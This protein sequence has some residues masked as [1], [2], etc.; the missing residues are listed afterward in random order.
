MSLQ[1][2]NV[3]I[4]GATSGFGAQIASV[5]SGER[6][7]VFIGGRRVDRGTQVAQDTNSTFHVVDVADEESCQTFFAAAEACFGGPNA[8]FIILNAGLGGTAAETVVPNL[9][10]QSF[11]LCFGVNVRGIFLGLQYGTPL[12]RTGGTFIFTSSVVSILPAAFNPVYG[13]SKAAVDSLVRSYAA[14]F[15][16]SPDARI[17]SLSVIAINPALYATE[18][19]CRYLKN[20]EHIFAATAKIY[21]PSQ[22]VG[23]AE[24]LA[25]IVRDLVTGKRPYKSGDT[26]ACDADTHFPLDE[27]VSRLKAGQETAKVES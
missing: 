2:K 20:D 4:T 3:I 8:D 5:L 9:N 10:V 11:D 19:S 23:K 18:M 1:G 13:A 22:R 21:N 24:E 16:E 6:A 15:A 25:V 17:Q 12:L 26:I 14:Q 27:Y 7:T